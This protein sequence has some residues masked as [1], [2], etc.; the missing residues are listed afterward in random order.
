MPRQHRTEITLSCVYWG[1]AHVCLPHVQ[2]L[3]NP[4]LVNSKLQI[5]T[6]LRMMV[7]NCAVHACCG[8]GCGAARA[9]VCWGI[10]LRRGYVRMLVELFACR[11]DMCSTIVTREQTKGTKM[12][13]TKQGQW[14]DRSAYKGSSC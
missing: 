5:E 11:R 2:V 1:K 9:H 10:P 4:G 6:N 12:R 14:I 8:C 7:G 3:P 13:F